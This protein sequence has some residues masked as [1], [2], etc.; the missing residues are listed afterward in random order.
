MGNKFNFRASLLSKTEFQS[1]FSAMY[2]DK[3]ADH[4]SEKYSIYPTGRIVDRLY[5]EGWAVASVAVKGTC[6]E[7]GALP[8]HEI[9]FRRADQSPVT[10]NVGDT[11]LEPRLTNSYDGW[12]KLSIDTGLFRLACS[13]GLLVPI[14]KSAS[15]SIRHLG[16]VADEVIEGV[17]R[18]VSETPRIGSV[19][20]NM[21]TTKLTYDQQREFALKA[22]TLRWEDNKVDPANLLDVRRDAD[23]GDDVWT[24]MNVVQENLLQGGF[25]NKAGRKVRAVTSFEEAARINQELFQLALV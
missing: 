2:E 10:P 14:T 7:S 6:D 15:Y 3:K 23:I 1:K 4:L 17:Y 11:I 21:R 5:D 13:N 12:S 25:R 18:V 16:H 20:E 19:I 22:S 9:R 24:T 8:K